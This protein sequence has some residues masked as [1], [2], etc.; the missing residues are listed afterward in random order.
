MKGHRLESSIQATQLGI[1]RQKTGCASRDGLSSTWL[2]LGLIGLG[3]S[4]LLACNNVPSKGT[5][6]ALKVTK[7]EA[8]SAPVKVDFLWVVDDSSSMCQEQASLA[9]SFDDF[10][11]RLET[12]VSLDYRLAV[13][14][15]DM[16]SEGFISQFRADK[17]DEF[18]FA[19][20]QKASAVCL[21]PEVLPVAEASFPQVVDQC[22]NKPE[23]QCDP[24]YECDSPSTAKNV[25][26]CNGTVNSGC[27]KTCAVDADCDRA[28]A[29]DAAG[30]ACASDPAQCAYK[31]LNPSGDAKGTGCVRRPSTGSCPD[32][33]TL[34][35][36]V[37]QGAGK[38]CDNGDSCDADVDCDTNGDGFHDDGDGGCNP[39]PYPWLT[40]KTA[41]DYF[42]CVG[43]VGA[44]QNINKNLE[45]GINAALWALSEAKGAPN[46][47]QS[48]KFLR[49]DA[50][51]VVVM[52]SDEED[53]STA[54]CGIDPKDGKW[55]CG[56]SVRKEDFGKCGCLADSR[57]GGPLLPVSVAINQVKALKADPGRVL[58]AAIV[59]DSQ[60]TDPVQ[61]DLERTLYAQSECGQCPNPADNH[62]DRAKTYICQSGSGQA[63]FG[64]RYAEF[65]SAFGSN[66]ILT[67]I[68]NDAGI[69]PALD[70]IA[71]RIIRVFTKVCLPRPVA[72]ASELAVRTI[73]PA[74]KCSD[75]S[76]CCTQQSDSCKASPSCGDG[77]KC[78]GIAINLP[79]GTEPDTASFQLSISGDCESVSLSEGVPSPNAVIFNSLLPPGT[80][81]E[82]DYEADY[83]GRADEDAVQGQ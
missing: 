6:F 24:G 12:F 59:G 9:D 61:K 18:P 1:E 8:N 50:Y 10:L 47:D 58:V 70:T 14:T 62:A 11:T 71:D 73:G 77:S 30:D 48:R 42:K 45:Q 4:L 76:D 39:P 46:A 53:C 37:I 82:I 36:A 44:D 35:D 38:V 25:L 15:T 41:K 72:D 49:D 81:I 68:C 3:S 57:N 75:L 28:F 55:K 21:R 27:R 31:C 66:G 79:Q 65:V 13:V 78:K 80:G 54:D 23:C 20:V 83:E 5:D 56:W 2:S 32:T 63:D 43:V 74:G 19:C 60:A 40:N 33:A 67:N 26:N 34:R 51:L 69:G 7:S 16:L 52:V 29:G 22:L 64:R 17:T